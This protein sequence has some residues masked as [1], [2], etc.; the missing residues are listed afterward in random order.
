ML[1]G[2]ADW[3]VKTLEKT[4]VKNLMELA[5]DCI[6]VWNMCT[7]TNLQRSNQLYKISRGFLILGKK[8]LVDL[9][10]LGQTE[11]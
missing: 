11:L 2:W 9:K 10:F 1:L 7:R 3:T 6:P 5:K 8:Y 4:G